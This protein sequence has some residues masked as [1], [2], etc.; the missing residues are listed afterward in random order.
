MIIFI[1]LYVFIYAMV[2]L[3]MGIGLLAFAAGLVDKELVY[4]YVDMYLGRWEPVAAFAVFVLV[5]LKVIYLILFCGYDPKGVVIQSTE[6]GRV[7]LTKQAL[8]KI[9]EKFAQKQSGL[10]NIVVKLNFNEKVLKIK[11]IADASADCMIADTSKLVQEEIAKGVGQCIGRNI[12][13]VKLII[14]DVSGQPKK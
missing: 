5:S 8:A 12:D 3:A 1:R 14:K 11:V 7:E 4:M 13:E 9:V 6:I 2:G 10:Q